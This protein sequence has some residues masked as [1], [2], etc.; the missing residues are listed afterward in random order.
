MAAPQLSSGIDNLIDIHLSAGFTNRPPQTELLREIT[1]FIEHSPKP[2]L[3][4]EASTGVGKTNALLL[5]AAHAIKSEKQA[6]AIISVP[7]LAVM[8]QY[9]P[10][11]NPKLKTL[12]ERLGI[13][14]GFAYAKREY[15]S[16]E[17]LQHYCEMTDDSQLIEAFRQYSQQA[18][19]WR[20]I[21][22]EEWLAREQPKEMPI[23]F[24]EIC[25]STAVSESDPGLKQYQ[26]ERD[27][28]ARNDVLV[29]THAM[30]TLDH[31][32]RLAEVYRTS[33]AAAIC[34][35][36]QYLEETRNNAMPG[37][38]G[39]T[40]ATWRND[41]L[42]KH[43]KD[44]VNSC[45]SE[46][47]V[48]P[49]CQFLLVDEAHS[50][51]DNMALA[52]RRDYSLHALMNLATK[53]QQDTP[54]L[55]SGDY[56]AL[57]E[58]C[59]AIEAIR[60]SRAG[61]YH[62]YTISR[63]SIARGDVPRKILRWMESAQLLFSRLVISMNEQP[64][65]SYS[66]RLLSL[67]LTEV[68]THLEQTLRGESK[69]LIHYSPV[70]GYARLSSGEAE[71]EQ[72]RNLLWRTKSKTV[73]VSGTLANG[74]KGTKQDYIYSINMLALAESLVK[75]VKPIETDWLRSNVTVHL[76][77]KNTRSL[78]PSNK[79]PEPFYHAQVKH[80]RNIRQRAKGGTLVLCTSHEAVERI[81]ELLNE[82]HIVY[83]APG[84]AIKQ[85]IL[86]FQELYKQNKRPIWV[87][88]GHWMGL[89]LTDTSA[90]AEHDNLIQNIVIQRL[91][92]NP[93]QSGANAISR[94]AFF[95]YTE[96][97]IRFK[98]GI[99][100]LVRRPGR[101]DMHIWVLDSRIARTDN[102]DYKQFRRILRP[103]QAIYNDLE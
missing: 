44:T 22:L 14:L 42:F 96:A 103:Y 7:T 89:D 95:R 6:R 101:K 84:K 56:A 3:L 29:C 70:R 97:V 34:A 16:Q 62:E 100:R 50:L 92:F 35:N 17:A 54:A 19:D 9:D 102:S 43:C 76:P 39:K 63:H 15:I 78:I 98:Q 82:E 81:A 60:D 25:L 99:G 20:R 72:L 8:R 30:L 85:Q 75:T 61:G 57:T 4:A 45:F 18:T 13:T 21:A 88:T 5:A 28:W 41:Q 73:Y 67:R 52:L 24:D 59:N 32:V 12:L 1:E 74:D 2:A 79:N 55:A 71:T 83:S 48:L 23:D 33:N 26:A 77:K 36:Q 64:P 31:Q 49:A 40:F 47:A 94:S 11:H 93:P 38:W 27:K 87:M 80:I 91:P 69:C 68:A 66:G 53:A 65:V 51:P 86:A 10:K 58:C 37:S 90:S 46:N